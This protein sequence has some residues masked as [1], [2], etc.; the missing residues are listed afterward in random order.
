MARDLELLP[1]MWETSMELL[2][3]GFSL[4]QTQLVR[5]F[6]DEAVDERS[7]SFLFSWKVSMCLSSLSL[8]R[9]AH[10]ED[11]NDLKS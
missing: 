9:Q 10:R 1:H 5:A 4:A 7:I 11:D 6:E 8:N 2:S 3:P